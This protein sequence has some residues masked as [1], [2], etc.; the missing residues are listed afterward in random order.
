MSASNANTGASDAQ[1]NIVYDNQVELAPD[2]DANQAVAAPAGEPNQ[3]DDAASITP[4]SVNLSTSSVTSSVLEYRQEN[5]RTYHGYKEGK[6]MLPNDDREVDRLDLQHNLFI[7]TF[8]GRLATAPPNDPDA[9]V[10]NVLDVGTGSGIWAMDFGDQHPEAE[11]RGFDLSA[12]FP[13]FTAPNV[14]FEIDD[15]EE[16]WTWTEPFDY[17]HSRMMNSS[18]SDWKAYIQK[19]YDHLSDGGYLEL[20]EIDCIPLSDDGTLTPEHSI[21]KTGNLLLEATT[22]AGRK[23]IYPPDLKAMMVEAGFDGVTMQLFKWPV[24]SWP[25]E[26]KYKEIGQWQNENLY[27]GW[28]AICMA[29]LTRALGWTKEEVT[30]LMAQNRQDF[31]NR[32]IHAYFPIW[33]IY[34]R[35]LSRTES[36]P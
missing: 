12:V 30:V 4:S 5:G 35:K 33:T 21:M 14:R 2:D 19:C 16:P 13:E 9:K 31:N 17:I 28:E 7:R 23:Y 18:I 34:G 26:Q 6:Y 27:Q 32:N 24:N 11:V 36:Q 15:L 20:I 22:N 8:D 1:P 29:P 10:K 3:D 25:K